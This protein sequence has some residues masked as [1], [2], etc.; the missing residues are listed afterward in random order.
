MSK[1]YKPSEKSLKYSSDNQAIFDLA[2]NK[3]Q[4]QFKNKVI[5]ELNKKKAQAVQNTMIG[6]DSLLIFAAGILEAIETVEEL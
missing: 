5:A 1:A 2:F 6:G 3:G 4:K